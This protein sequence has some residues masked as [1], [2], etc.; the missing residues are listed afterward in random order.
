MHT[1]GSSNKIS[2]LEQFVGL[3]ITIP[4][5]VSTN[6]LSF[7]GENCMYFWWWYKIRN[8]GRLKM[9][10]LLTFLIGWFVSK[11]IIANR[12][13]DSQKTAAN[14][15]SSEK[16]IVSACYVITYSSEIK[17]LYA[18]NCILPENMWGFSI[19]L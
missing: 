11:S 6:K 18:I 19:D 2:L 1:T 13:F 5:V 9:V 14:V 8:S 12:P 3:I 17:I 16:F 10:K 4:A 7:F 15:E